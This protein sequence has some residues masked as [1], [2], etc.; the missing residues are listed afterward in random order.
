MVNTL[1]GLMRFLTS[2]WPVEKQELSRLSYTSREGVAD[3]T[4]YRT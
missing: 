4:E 2:N 1:I 3:D